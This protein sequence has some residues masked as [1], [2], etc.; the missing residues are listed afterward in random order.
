[1]NSQQ[2]YTIELPFHPEQEVWFLNANRM[3]TRATI[4]RIAF[5][6]TVFKKSRDFYKDI[7]YTLRPI[8]PANAKP[9]IMRDSGIHASLDE[10][11]DVLRTTA[12]IVNRVDPPEHPP[13]QPN[14]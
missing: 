12:M 7:E 6:L 9:V 2:P 5:S 1:M 14:E 4:C 3:P 8:V 10:L 13:T 11:M